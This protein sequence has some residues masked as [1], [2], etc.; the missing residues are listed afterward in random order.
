MIADH[1]LSELRAYRK[2]ESCLPLREEPS[3][4]PFVVA[5]GNE[6]LPVHR[7]FRFK[8]AYSGGLLKLLL[9]RFV[10]G[11]KEIDL[12]DPFCGVGT[13]LLSAQA[14]KLP[15][16]NALGIE[17]NPFIRFAAATKLSWPDIDPQKMLKLAGQVI[18]AASAP[19]DSIP[20]LSGFV[21]GRCMS[22][23]IARR[24]LGIRNAISEDGDTSNHRALLLGLA[25]SIE[26]LSYTRKDGRA[27]RLVDRTRRLVVPALQEKWLQIAN[28]VGDLQ[29][30]CPNPGL[31]RVLAGDGRSISSY[32]IP[33]CSIDFII[34]S[35]PYLN[36]IDYSEV[37]KLELWLM[38]FI[39][40][41]KSFLQ[42]RKGTLRSH[43]TSQ[44]NGEESDFVEAVTRNRLDRSFEII[45]SKLDTDKEKWRRKLFVAY[46]SDILSSLKEQYNVL[47]AGGSALII[48]GNSLH[49]GKYA[50]YVIA[51]DLL[52][53]ELARSVG[54]SLQR[55]SIARSLRRR[56]T[57]NHFLRE[58][59]IALRRPSA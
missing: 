30:S 37:Y 7:W 2:L 53:C 43:P 15:R 17:Y 55:L 52:I 26:P 38:G 48:V 42:L 46:F 1:S 51:T 40:D 16:I 39:S 12:L 23:H 21:T 22:H 59:V 29:R 13:T 57:G 58:S 56:L 41:S 9:P 33:P 34:T 20:E 10:N 14:Q 28:D 50:P 11:K 3:L 36:N 44:L 8:E 6:D 45:L 27:L 25:A 5:G 18:S 49:G 31:T 47:R 54:F 24:L 32:S 4:G 35:P 19:S